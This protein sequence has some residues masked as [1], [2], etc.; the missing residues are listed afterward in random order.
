MQA[1]C[2]RCGTTFEA[3]SARAKWCSDRCRKAKVRAEA[4]VHQLRRPA[5]EPSGDDPSTTE[6]TRAALE[7]A[8]RLGTPL[9]AASL[10]L[11]REIDQQA[12]APLAALV[13]QLQST[14]EA[15]LAG[16]KVADDPLDELAAHRRRR[17]AGGA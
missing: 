8:D 11:A 3:R 10:K 15:A 13:K 9:G 12:G 5:P 14:L 2:A 6:A 1:Q 17:L 16:V 7:S 4:R